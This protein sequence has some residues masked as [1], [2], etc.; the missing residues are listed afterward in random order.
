MPLSPEKVP[1]RSPIHWYP[2]IDST[3]HEAVRLANAGCEPGTVV[4]ADEQTAGQGRFGRVWHSAPDAGLYFSIVLGPSDPLVTLALGLATASAIQQTT[5]VGCD[6]RW[7]NDVLIGERKVAGILTQLHG[8]AVV[9]GIGINVN[10]TQF[11]PDVAGIATSLRIAGR[12]E[13]EREPLLAAVL[14]EI[15]HHV[16]RPGAAILDLFT[17][18]SSYVSGRRVTVDD[19]LTGTTA[20]L[21]EEGYLNLRLDDGRREIVMAGGVRPATGLRPQTI[22]K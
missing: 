10:Q 11:P 1:W 21:T 12:R 2:T 9:A 18:A 4:G 6:L 14:D 7:P 15:D 17:R 16:T 22:D 5:G 8:D 13:Q 3:M 20:G 19:R